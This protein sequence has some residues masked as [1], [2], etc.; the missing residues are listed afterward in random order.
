MTD[1]QRLGLLLLALPPTIADAAPV[2]R[3]A[4]PERFA[5]AA[6]V[7]LEQEVGWD[8][9]L[10][11][12]AKRVRKRVLVLR[13]AGSDQADQFFRYDSKISVVRSFTARTVQPDG[14]ILQVP[15]DLRH[16]LVAYRSGT[17][18]V[19]VVLFTFPGV[20]VGS[21]LEWDYQI[22][23][24]QSRY[25]QWW[26]VQEDIPV[27]HA[28]FTI[29]FHDFPTMQL[30]VGPAARTPFSTWCR[31]V[32][33]KAEAG[34]VVRRYE[35]T[36]LPAFE[37]EDLSP[38]R[39]ESQLRI[40][41]SWRPVLSKPL[42]PIMWDDLGTRLRDQIRR[43]SKDVGSARGVSSELQAGVASESELVE[44]VHGWVRTNLKVRS[45]AEDDLQKG[46]GEAATVAEIL[47]RGGG[48][49]NEVAIAAMVL[50][51]GAGV[52]AHP[53]LV[54]DRTSERIDWSF[55][56]PPSD[57]HV[58]L[59]VTADGQTEFL[60]P[61][62]DLCGPGIVDWRYCAGDGSGVRVDPETAA[63]TGV[64]VTPRGALENSERFKE[65]IRLR[66]DG[67]ASVEGDVRWFGQFDLVMRRQWFDLTPSGR[68]ETLRED[69]AG[70]VEGFEA[71]CSDPS[72][73]GEAL[74]ASYRYDRSDLALA[75]G[76]RLLLT[77]PD[78][79]TTS[80]VLPIQEERSLPVWWLFPYSVT[81]ETSFALPDGFSV[82][83]VPPPI[84]LRG[85]GLEFKGQWV[86]EPEAGR[87]RWEGRLVYERISIEPSDYPDARGF[88]TDLASSLRKGIVAIRRGTVAAK[89]GT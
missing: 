72:V 65:Q 8:V 7:V 31:N 12:S 62:C 85:P 51:L 34:Q 14:T 29:W 42:A 81:Q 63:V 18:E 2:S 86:S 35:C 59:E 32:P 28:G 3:P 17:S 45:V 22:D 77:A 37:P 79:F 67:G 19:R 75:V 20:R 53:V 46:R 15:Q 26:D 27:L 54:G 4:V 50:L 60:D 55:P 49:P 83:N 78:P 84:E 9:S 68:Q 76:D 36:D 33:R 80:L 47:E 52:E 74:V 21:I 25:L 89:D 69:I 40:L 1:I 13:D 61:G 23:S 43:L 39:Y 71:R 6:A 16:D 41:M 57:P 30:S 70:D 87:V 58:L 44:R 38:P 11:K 5:G 66:E 56:D 10:N 82:P 88:A 24:D 64:D 48:T 73:S